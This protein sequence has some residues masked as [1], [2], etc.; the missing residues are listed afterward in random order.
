MRH[1]SSLPSILDGEASFVED[2]KQVDEVTHRTSLAYLD[3]SKLQQHIGL[4]RN[5]VG[6]GFEVGGLWTDLEKY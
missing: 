3:L 5:E 4:M 1:C 2:L 6:K